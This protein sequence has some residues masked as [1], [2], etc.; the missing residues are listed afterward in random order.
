MVHP[1][2]PIDPFSIEQASVGWTKFVNIQ[3]YS[4]LLCLSHL[5]GGYPR[6]KQNKFYLTN[7]L[8]MNYLTLSCKYLSYI[9]NNF[10]KF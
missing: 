7:E 3:E 6:S 5:T 9:S 2:L 1:V 10:K 4:L 8:C